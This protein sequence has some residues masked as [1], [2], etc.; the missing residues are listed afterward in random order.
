M[1]VIFWGS[2][3]DLKFSQNI[4]INIIRKSNETFRIRAQIN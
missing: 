4:I 3:K 2:V 1:K